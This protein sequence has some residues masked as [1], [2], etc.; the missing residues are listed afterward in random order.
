MAVYFIRDAKLP[1]VKIGYSYSP[2]RRLKALKSEYRRELQLLKT[3]Y[4]YR[5]EE[6]A[7]HR[8]FKQYRLHGEWFQLTGELVRFIGRRRPAKVPPRKP[9]TQILQ[10]TIRDLLAADYTKEQAASTLMMTVDGLDEIL[11]IKFGK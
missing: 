3:I 7:L 8:K 5:A 6:A 2:E 1:E 9:F 10:E 4:G 11:A